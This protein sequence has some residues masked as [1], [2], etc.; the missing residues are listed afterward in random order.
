MDDTDPTTSRIFLSAEFLGA[1]LNLADS[2]RTRGPLRAATLFAL[3]T[4][5]PA[6]GE[7]LVTG[8]FRLLRQR[9]QPRVGNVPLA[10]L[11]LWYNVICGVHAATE[12]TLSRL[13]LSAEQRRESLPLA[14][15]LVATSLDLVM[16]PVGLEVGLWEWK[17]DGAYAAEVQGPNG[18]KGVPVLNYLGWMVVVMGTLLVYVRLFPRGSAGSRLPVILLLPHY[19]ASV[20]WAIR[21]RRPAYLLYSAPFPMVL[22]LGFKEN[23]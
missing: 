8:P 9:T 4:G 19:L 3:S 1:S 12:H 22:Y 11:L 20:G 18:R 16:D 2:V 15:A 23:S 21:R 6:F 13:P 10:I 5:L 14:T 7:L 17:R